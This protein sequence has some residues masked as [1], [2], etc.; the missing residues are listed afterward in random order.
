MEGEDG[1]DAFNSSENL[2]NADKAIAGDN[3]A[4]ALSPTHKSPYA[5]MSLFSGESNFD[6]NNNQIMEHNLKMALQLSLSSIF[7]HFH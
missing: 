7:P 1:Q 6:I 2:A 4:V 5:N 3:F